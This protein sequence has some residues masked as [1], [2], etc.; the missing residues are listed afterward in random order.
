M[1]QKHPVPRT[2]VFT[3][4]APTLAEPEIPKREDNSP[5]TPQDIAALKTLAKMAPAINQLLNAGRVTEDEEEE[6]EE[7]P[8]PGPGQR[9][10][11]GKTTLDSRA[12]RLG[13]DIYTQPEHR[14]IGDWVYDNSGA[15]GAA[16]THDEAATVPLGH[17][18]YT[19]PEYRKLGDTMLQEQGSGLVYR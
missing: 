1:S 2:R 17:D 3:C 5:F 13:D 16:V 19:N 18:I 7:L 10:V 8:G 15:R 12:R 4:D 9:N 6:V 11:P 14:K